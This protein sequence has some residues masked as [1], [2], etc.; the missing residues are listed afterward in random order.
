MGIGSYSP[1]PVYCKSPAQGY[2]TPL[3]SEYDEK[4]QCVFIVG[5][6]SLHFDEYLEFYRS[7]KIPSPICNIRIFTDY[8][9]ADSSGLS[10]SGI[11]QMKSIV[12][13]I[14][15]RLES[16]REAFVVKEPIASGLTRMYGRI[17]YSDKY[18]MNVFTDINEA[19]MR[20]GLEPETVL[21]SVR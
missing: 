9:E 15:K 21:E 11:E 12:L 2:I 8:R 17:D 4:L 1:C 19:K 7:V 16:I 14:S 13:R 5:K 18:E 6:G 10:T 3:H 20:L